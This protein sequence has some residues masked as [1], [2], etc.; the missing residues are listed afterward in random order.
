[1]NATICPN[2]KTSREGTSEKCPD[3]GY[4]FLA[5]GDES[6]AKAVAQ[7]ILQKR[8]LNEGKTAARTVRA[9]FWI[10]GVLCLVGSAVVNTRGGN[11]SIIFIFALVLIGLGFL[12]YVAPL[13]ATS[14]A[15]LYYIFSYLAYPLLLGAPYLIFSGIIYKGLIL[16]I[17]I[18]G[19]TKSLKEY[20]T[21]LKIKKA[22]H[23]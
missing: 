21:K 17:L 19:F 14:I 4:L 3:C 22:S 6:K 13:A 15:L 10:L 18:Y 7:Q 23:I 12:T 2:C 16:G 8:T 1:M 9:L 5:S 20:Q 11:S